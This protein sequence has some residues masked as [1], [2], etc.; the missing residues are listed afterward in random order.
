MPL[1]FLNRFPESA[2]DQAAAHSKAESRF[3]SHMSHELRTPAAGVVG[4]LQLALQQD[5]APRTRRELELGL[6]QSE[7]QLHLIDELLDLAKMEA[8]RFQLEFQPVEVYGNLEQALS[9]LRTLAKEKGL[10][11][12]CRMDI[13]RPTWVSSDPRRMR[14]LWMNLIGSAIRVTKQGSV[15]IHVSRI[16]SADAPLERLLVQVQTAGTDIHGGTVS[17]DFASTD[18]DQNGPSDPVSGTGLGMSV[19]RHWIQALGGSLSVDRRDEKSTLNLLLPCEEVDPPLESRLLEAT[20][21]ARMECRLRILLVD[22]VAT[23]RYIAQAMLE[24]LGQKVECAEDGKQAC[25]KCSEQRFDLVILDMRMP[26]MNGTEAAQCIRA[27]GL[28]DKPVLDSQMRLIALTANASGDDKRRCLECG[29]DGFLV[30]PLRED[31]LKA[32]LSK[33]IAAQQARGFVLPFLEAAGDGNW[34]PAPSDAPTPTWTPNAEQPSEPRTGSTKIQK[35]WPS[36]ARKRLEALRDALEM[37]DWDSLG[38]EAH[39]VKGA[40]RYLLMPDLAKTAE[41]LEEAADRKLDRALLVD[42]T[43]NLE[44]AIQRSLDSKQVEG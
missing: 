44:M 34:Q 2:R 20:G 10:D 3:L 16:H 37:G 13:A 26:V 35:M 43:A 31:D 42:L 41:V 15:H 7:F 40:A 12:H 21:P 24:K 18:P 22:D 1:D 36:E 38:R 19:S 23:N 30:K 11:L 27:G 8:G 9:P 17:M 32:E 5:L 25:V 6:A 29:M 14:Q 33:A 4:I 39:N 28:P